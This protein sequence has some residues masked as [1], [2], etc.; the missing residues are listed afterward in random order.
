MVAVE[1]YAVLKNGN[2]DNEV[3]KKWKTNSKWNRNE[4]FGSETLTLTG[5]ETEI[6]IELETETEIELETEIE[7]ETEIELETETE[8][9]RDYNKW[10]KEK[11]GDEERIKTDGEGR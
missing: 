7:I 11:K 6:E 2:Y 3:R 1:A 4:G 8:S 5:T 10:N 9:H